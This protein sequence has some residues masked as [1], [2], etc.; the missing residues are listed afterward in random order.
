MI[1]IATD[2]FQITNLDVSLK[3]LNNPNLYAN[4]V[5]SVYYI[6]YG[7]CIL[8]ILFSRYKKVGLIF[9]VISILEDIFIKEYTK[10]VLIVD[11]IISLGLFLYIVW[12]KIYKKPLQHGEEI[13]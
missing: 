12:H 1:S 11:A 6:L 10:E 7:I 13:K 3:I 5:L 4:M 8:V 2:I 9:V